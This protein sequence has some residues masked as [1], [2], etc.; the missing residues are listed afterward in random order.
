[1]TNEL[2]WPVVLGSKEF[3]VFRYS[4]RNI[5]SKITN[6]NTATKRSQNR[7]IP[8]INCKNDCEHG[9]NVAERLVRPWFGNGDA[10]LPCDGYWGKTRQSDKPMRLLS[11]H[12]RPL[13]PLLVLSSRLVVLEWA[14]LVLRCN[15]VIRLLIGLGTIV[16]SHL[17]ILNFARLSK[18]PTVW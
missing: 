15:R 3:S 6:N 18:M 8:R 7:Y 5:N 14:A 17:L 4:T 1:M 13:F 10:C 2:R 11:P 12:N 16:F 9:R